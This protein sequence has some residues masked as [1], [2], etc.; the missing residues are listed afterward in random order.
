MGILHPDSLIEV[1]LSFS[2]PIEESMSIEF[3]P[4]EDATVL[5]YENDILLG[6]LTHGEA[7]KYHLDYHPRV[8]RQ[9]RIEAQV[10]DWATLTATDIIPKQPQVEIV[11]KILE[12]SRS[13]ELTLRLQDIDENKQVYYLVTLRE[14][15]NNLP[16]DFSI[17]FDERVR[18]GDSLF[19][20][21][22]G[23]VTYSGIFDRF[24]QTIG[25]DGDPTF[26]D[27]GR[28]EDNIFN[29]SEVSFKILL[30]VSFCEDVTSA[31]GVDRFLAKQSRIIHL[32]NAS[33]EYDPYLKS[34]LIHNMIFRTRED[35]SSDLEYIDPLVEPTR[36]HS[37]V[38][39]GLGI[40]A[41]Y[42]SKTIRLP[43]ER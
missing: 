7:G 21:N 11:D 1:S 26:R 15:L 20:E 37:N 35:G 43:A 33:A 17:P 18:C 23:F 36:I 6:T 12:P 27:F 30:G 5:L 19:T 32:I 22:F 42:N 40:F 13:L 24:N 25:V 14:V 2:R 39:N 16:T 38:K 29:G 9:Y 28:L 4:I 34:T 41:A 31:D 8:D 3:T 10:P